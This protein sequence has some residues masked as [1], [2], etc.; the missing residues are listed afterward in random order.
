MYV[1]KGICALSGI[2]FYCRFCFE[3]GLLVVAFVFGIY[4]LYSWFGMLFRKHFYLKRSCDVILAV[5]HYTVMD[6]NVV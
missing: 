3:I 1:K 4:S 5:R 2:N 6:V